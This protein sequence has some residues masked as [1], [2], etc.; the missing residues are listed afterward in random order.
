MRRYLI[1]KRIMMLSK[2]KPRRKKHPLLVKKSL[3]FNFSREYTDFTCQKLSNKLRH[4]TTQKKKS[5]QKNEKNN[6]QRSTIYTLALT[7][8][9][10][11]ISCFPPVMMTFASLLSIISHL[12]ESIHQSLWFVIFHSAHILCYNQARLF[13]HVKSRRRF[14][15]DWA[16]NRTHVH[17][18]QRKDLEWS[19]EVGLGLS[20]AFILQIPLRAL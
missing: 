6:P 14:S 3:T 4:I 16:G 1:L 17:Y 7:P 8:T 11:R 9:F 10:H 19:H 12:S 5:L 13:N 18:L 15:S 2:R 20:D